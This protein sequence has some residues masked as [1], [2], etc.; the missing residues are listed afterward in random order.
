ML[1]KEKA[2][3]SLDIHIDKHNVPGLV[4]YTWKRLF[5]LVETNKNTIADRG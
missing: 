4:S 3:M 5:V 1:A 2:D